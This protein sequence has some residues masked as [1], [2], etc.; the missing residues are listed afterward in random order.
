[1]I[2]RKRMCAGDGEAG[3]DGHVGDRGGSA[4][5]C[6]ESSTFLGRFNSFLPVREC[7]IGDA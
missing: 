1:M 4:P 5:K 7:D 6:V 3:Q 2:K